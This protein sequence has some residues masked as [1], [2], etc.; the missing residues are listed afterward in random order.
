MISNMMRFPLSMF[1]DDFD[2]WFFP[3]ISNARRV[4]KTA[5]P[6]VNVGTTDKHVDVYLFAPGMQADDLDVVIE[7]NL[8]SV[9]GARK[10]D[11][12]G[13]S[14]NGYSRKE[15][16]EGKFKR[17]ITLPEEVDAESAEANYRE[18]VLHIRIAKPAAV[19]PKQIEVTVH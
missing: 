11:Q 16:Y 19:Q 10:L 18:G 8:L 4:N 9:A 12:A 1:D 7:K 14:E 13:E 3:E 17:V 6:P 2:R 15:R 5:Y